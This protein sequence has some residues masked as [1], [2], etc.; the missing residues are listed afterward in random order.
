MTREYKY[1]LY[2]IASPSGTLYTGISDNLIRRVDEH[3]SKVKESF[4]KKYSCS[5]LIYFE[6]CNN[7]V[8]A[9]KREKQIKNWRREKKE[10]LIKMLNPHWNNLCEEYFEN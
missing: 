2:I 1:Y 8:D 10:T 5:K 3:R 9:I 4:T 7:S 6:E